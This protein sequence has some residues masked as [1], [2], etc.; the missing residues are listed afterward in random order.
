M[1]SLIIIII[2]LTLGVSNIGL[3]QPVSNS[4]RKLPLNENGQINNNN[5]TVSSTKQAR[6]GP[7]I[8]F[9]QTVYNFGTVSP[10]E[11][12]KCCFVFYNKGDGPLL[13]KNVEASCGCTVPSWIKKPLMPGDSSVINAVFYPKDYEGQTVSKV[14][15]VM[16]YIKENGQDKNITLYLKGSIMK[17]PDKN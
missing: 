2:F 8:Q 5:S 17:K 10:D 7:V 6:K 16:T 1:K 3:T 12:V 14:I 9:K 15:T 13:L 4:K 11:D